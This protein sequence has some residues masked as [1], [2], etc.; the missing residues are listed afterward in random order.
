MYRSEI[1]APR[2]VQ[3][4]PTSGIVQTENG[5]TGQETT[6]VTLDTRRIVASDPKR[7]RIDKV[8][9]S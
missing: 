5:L 2:V 8:L 4:N 3:H 9:R 7:N 6:S 1:S